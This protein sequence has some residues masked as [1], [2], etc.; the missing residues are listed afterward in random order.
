MGSA[1]FVPAGGCSG[2]LYPLGSGAFAFGG[3]PFLDFFASGIPSELSRARGRDVFAGGSGCAR[4]SPLLVDCLVGSS[5]GLAF[6]GIELEV[7]P[8]V[9]FFFG[10]PR[11]GVGFCTF[12]A[13]DPGFSGIASIDG[14]GFLEGTREN[15]NPSSSCS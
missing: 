3:R 8:L 4:F 15:S 1:T 2:D 5:A 9:G 14:L 12:S 13:S 7:A 10:R 6:A 11:F